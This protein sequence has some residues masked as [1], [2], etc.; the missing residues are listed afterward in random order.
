MMILASDLIRIFDVV[1][2]FSNFVGG[3]LQDLNLKISNRSECPMVERSSVP[4][5]E[6]APLLSGTS[7]R[8]AG[9]FRLSAAISAEAL[10]LLFSSKKRL[11]AT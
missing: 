3:R 7:V 5:S 11:A 4:Q 9:T 1:V 8:D 2:V 6:G 10:M